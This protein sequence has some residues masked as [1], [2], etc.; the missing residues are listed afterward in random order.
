MRKDG[1]EFPVEVSFSSVSIDGH[2]HGTGIVRDIS[3]RRRAE[4]VHRKLAAIV[5]SSED[6]IIGMTTDG[7]ITTW[8]RGAAKVYGYETEEIVGR[9]VSVLVPDDLKHEVADLLADVG[10]GKS[11]VHYETTRQSND[12]RQIEVSLSL[13]PIRDSSGEINGISAIDRDITERKAAEKEIEYLAF[14]DSLTRLPNRRLLLDR[15]QQALVGSYA[16]PAQGRHSVH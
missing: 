13:S 10:A 12:G 9:S 5:E 16:Q 8:N 2:W 6:A 11:V 1:E 7:F 4:A 3:E 14:Y 15:L